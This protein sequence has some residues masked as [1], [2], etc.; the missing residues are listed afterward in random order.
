MLLRMVD[1]YENESYFIVLKIKGNDTI[2]NTFI[3][4][5]INGTRFREYI[6][7]KN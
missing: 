4:I 5:S 3:F 1:K 2:F 7:K 6:L